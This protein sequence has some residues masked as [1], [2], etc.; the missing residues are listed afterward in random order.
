MKPSNGKPHITLFFFTICS[1]ASDNPRRLKPYICALYRF[2]GRRLKAKNGE[3][4]SGVDADT[5]IVQKEFIVQRLVYIKGEFHSP[6]NVVWARLDPEYK[7]DPDVAFL[8]EH[9]LKVNINISA[10]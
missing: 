5:V 8:F 3:S 6:E 7:H 2:I 10:V 9:V 4:K 1:A